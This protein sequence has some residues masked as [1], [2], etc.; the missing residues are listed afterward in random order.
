MMS[1]LSSSRF[2]IRRRTGAGRG[3]TL[4]ELLVAMALITLIM[5]VLSQA[6]VQG[7]NTFR[8]LKAVGDMNERLRAA[9]IGLRS[10][11]A[12]AHFA[13]NR[14]IEESLRTGATDA[15]AVADLRNR[16]TAISE[17]ATELD[18]GLREVGRQTSNPVGRRLLGRLLEMLGAIKSGAVVMVELLDLLDFIN[19][20]PPP[21]VE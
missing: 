13:I 18:E 4:I 15:E 12:A 1:A 11:V 10:D 5:S 17:D 21:P 16:F 19:P 20:P 7:A 2:A 14:L 3:F 9:V 8:D 6:F